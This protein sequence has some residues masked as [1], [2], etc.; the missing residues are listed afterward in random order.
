MKSRSTLDELRELLDITQRCVTQAQDA[1]R[2]V[3]RYA[4]H[5]RFQ[6]EEFKKLAS[7]A[8]SPEMSYRFLRI[9]AANERLAQLA[10]GEDRLLH[11][12]SDAT[13]VREAPLDDE[14][15]PG[16]AAESLEQEVTRKPAESPLEQAHRHVVQAEDQVA[17]QRA[18]VEK[19]SQEEKHIALAAEAREILNTLEHTLVLARQHLSLELKR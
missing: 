11:P 10:T 13:A 12:S 19:L 5:Y 15:M 1:Q 18:L 2:Q 17:R 3:A 16:T 6:V 8:H 4:E 14:R 9:A 7:R